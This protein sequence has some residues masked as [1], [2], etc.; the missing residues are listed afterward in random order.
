MLVS[1]LKTKSIFGKPEIS[2]NDKIGLRK[3]HQQVEI[4]NTWLLSIGYEN[5]ILSDEN[6]PKAGTRFPNY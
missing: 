1:H 4:T 3:Y 5:A 6:L 2:P